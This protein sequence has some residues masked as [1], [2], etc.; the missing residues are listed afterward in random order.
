MKKIGTKKQ[1]S[2]MKNK[3]NISDCLFAL[4]LM[5]TFPLCIILSNNFSFSYRW[6][7]YIFYILL[8]MVL[9]KI[10][11]AFFSKKEAMVYTMIYCFIYIFNIIDRFRENKMCNIYKS[12]VKEEN[13]PYL[14]EGCRFIKIQMLNSIPLG[15]GIFLVNAY[16]FFIS[17]K[18]FN[19]KK[20]SVLNSF[21]L[22][23]ILIVF[24]LILGF[25]LP[26]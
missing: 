2:L 22:G 13:Y 25:P 20:L 7:L 1:R 16:S 4:L 23:I 15:L 14:I 17:K 10:L 9:I 18:E 24:I 12:L 26:V 3:M 8:M 21:F 6:G 5:G 19:H 11:K